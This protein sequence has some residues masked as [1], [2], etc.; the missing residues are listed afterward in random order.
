MWADPVTGSSGMPTQGAKYLEMK[1]YSVPF[2]LIVI[3]IPLTWSPVSMLNN[4][5]LSIYKIQHWLLYYINLLD[6]ILTFKASKVSLEVPSWSLISNFFVVGDKRTC[7]GRK[8]TLSFSMTCIN[9]QID[10]D[11]ALSSKLIDGGFRGNF[12]STPFFI[13]GNFNAFKIPLCLVTKLIS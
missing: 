1:S 2:P 8:L 9:F 12:I 3:I 13:S 11:L 4:A 6:F 7:F 5:S 10:S